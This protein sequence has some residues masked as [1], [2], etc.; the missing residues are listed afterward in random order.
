[1]KVNAPSCAKKKNSNPTFHKCA[2]ILHFGS[3]LF[4]FWSIGEEGDFMR[5]E[6]YRTEKK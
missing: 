5:E 3:D 4:D 6:I 1:V 2:S